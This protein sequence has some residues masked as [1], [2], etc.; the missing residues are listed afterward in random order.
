MAYASFLISDPFLCPFSDRVTAVSIAAVVSCRFVIYEDETEAAEL[1]YRT[2]GVYCYDSSLK[3]KVQNFFLGSV[4]MFVRFA[5]TFTVILGAF[6][7]FLVWKG[8]KKPHGKC[9]Y[10]GLPGVLVRPRY[11]LHAVPAPSRLLLELQGV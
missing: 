7:V 8:I 9:M 4:A 10:N 2:A 5:A 6:A 11:V 1:T 3:E